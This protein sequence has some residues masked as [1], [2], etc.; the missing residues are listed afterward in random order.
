LTDSLEHLSQF[1]ISRSSSQRQGYK[2]ERSQTSVIEYT[3]SRVDR[4]RLKCNL[5]LFENGVV[6]H[7]HLTEA[8]RDN[9]R[10]VTTIHRARQIDIEGRSPRRCKQHKT[11]QDHCLPI[12]MARR[13]S[14]CASDVGQW[15]IAASIDQIWSHKIV[16]WAKIDCEIWSAP[17]M[18]AIATRQWATCRLWLAY[19]TRSDADSPPRKLLYHIYSKTL[20]PAVVTVVYRCLYSY[21]LL[22]VR[23][24]S[25]RHNERKTRCIAC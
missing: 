18:Y 20:L 14:S 7:R 9:E 2:S 4:L 6:L 13:L 8:S 5:V 21:L 1:S 11:V 3:H 25:P 24:Q 12:D 22:T 15:L 17:S 19:Y 16:R 23:L 10:L